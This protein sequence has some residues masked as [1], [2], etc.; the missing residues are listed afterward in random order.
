MRL[1]PDLSK[2][3]PDFLVFALNARSVREQV[4]E[5]G[6][7]TAGNIGISAANAKS[8]V[9]PV[10]PLP[11]QRRIVA[12]LDSLQAEVDAAKHLQ[13]ETTAKLD[14]L[15]PSILDRAFKGQL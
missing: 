13:A 4:E 5:L 1:R 9:V 7:T 12:E 3:S 10:P 15:L 11:E 8:F 6:K 2:M 14:A